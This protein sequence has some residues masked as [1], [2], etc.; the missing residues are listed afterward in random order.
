MRLFYDSTCRR[1]IIL[2]SVSLLLVSCTPAPQLNVIGYLVAKRT[3]R[4]ATTYQGPGGTLT[5]RVMAYGEPIVGATVVV[6][7][8]TGTPHVAQSDATGHYRIEQIP[9]GHYVPAAIAPYPYPNLS[10]RR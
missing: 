8:R 4:L 9:P 6:A 3:G 1:L 10:L 7:E 5:G 2:C